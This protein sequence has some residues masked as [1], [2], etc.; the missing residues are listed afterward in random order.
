[1][2]CLDCGLPELENGTVDALEGTTYNKYITYTCSLGFDLAGDNV[3]YCQE[4]GQWNG[5]V[6]FCQPK[7][8]TRCVTVCVEHKG[9]LLASI[10]LVISFQKSLE[11]I[12]FSCLNRNRIS[13]IFCN[14]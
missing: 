5:S 8:I 11:V 4:N 13:N 2:F 1:M 14:C 9:L 3:Q 10:R 12:Y 6:P 7:G